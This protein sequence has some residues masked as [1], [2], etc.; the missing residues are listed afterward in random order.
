MEMEGVR[1][2][3]AILRNATLE[4]KRSTRLRA[5]L[6]V[7]LRLGNRLNAATFR[8]GAQ[9]FQ[10]EALV[11][12]KETR[13]AQSNSMC[14]TLLHYLAKV[15]RRSDP[16]LVQ[17]QEELP[18]LEEAS[19][20]APQ[21]VFVA[22]QTL[23]KGLDQVKQTIRLCGTKNPQE[24]FLLV[25]QDF[26][27]RSEPQVTALTNMAN[28]VEHSLGDV[29]AYFGE[30]GDEAMKPEDF[31]ALVLTF[32]SDLQKATLE[33]PEEEPVTDAKHQNT[34]SGG[35]DGGSIV[36]PLPNILAQPQKHLKAPSLRKETVRGRG[37]NSMIRG[38]FDQTLRSMKDGHRTTRNR[39]SKI[40]LD[41]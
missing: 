10:M 3:L 2:E 34:G 40:F 38:Q 19:R 36:P 17:F 16:N 31:F 35:S 30:A 20:L 32:S 33:L 12:L 13:T 23:S 11:K 6:Q 21:A 5:I 27:A 14:P 9:G 22:A 28:S 1:P 25:M 26:V 8:G 29:L 7:V 18:H 24:K 15:L 39:L 4:L 41:S 37:G